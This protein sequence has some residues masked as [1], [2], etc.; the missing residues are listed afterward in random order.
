[1]RFY[2]GLVSDALNTIAGMHE[3]RAKLW[4]RNGQNVRFLVNVYRSAK[5]CRH[6]FTGNVHMCNWY[7]VIMMLGAKCRDFRSCTCN[8]TVKLAVHECIRANQAWSA[9]C[10]FQNLDRYAT[11]ARNDVIVW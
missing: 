4:L 1:M 7:K 11:G 8:T 6:G 5:F 9:S 2:H 10:V 3:I